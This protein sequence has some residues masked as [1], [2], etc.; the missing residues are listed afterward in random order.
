MADG[1]QSG[2]RSYG[3]SHILLLLSLK[4]IL[5]AF[6]ILLN[7][8]SEFQEDKTRA[9][10]DSVTR[11]FRG[12]FEP[13]ANIMPHA[14]NLGILPE[15]RD[16]LRR[17]GSAFESLVPAAR[18]EWIDRALTLRLEVPAAD[19]FETGAAALRPEPRA[20]LEELVQA[21]VR[22]RD[23][24]TAL[25]LEVLHGLPS[26]WRA[27][28]DAQGSSLEVR[29]TGALVQALAG[30]GAPNEALAVGLVPERPNVVQFILRPGAE[31]SAAAAEAQ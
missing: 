6:F 15:V 1:A 28:A 3:H 16:N 19:L 14:A 12:D 24:G 4:L 9:V 11:T 27:F 26:G 25:D 13:N 10:L 18:S 2:R 29:R 5:L 20:L 31:A 21:V 30:I 17:I 8:L 22:A 7:A 23:R